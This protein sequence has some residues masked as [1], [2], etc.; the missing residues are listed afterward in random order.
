MVACAFN[1]MTQEAEARA[2]G[3]SLVYRI[4]SR[5]CLKKTKKEVLSSL[6]RYRSIL[7][8]YLEKT[9]ELVSVGVTAPG[10]LVTGRTQQYSP[11][12]A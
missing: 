1:S 8:S 9:P 3:A 5:T 6:R 2:G 10:F 7:G 4:S 12:S 11:N